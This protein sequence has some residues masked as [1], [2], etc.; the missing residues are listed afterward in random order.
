[1]NTDNDLNHEFLELQAGE[2]PE[3][4]FMGAMRL[5]A[6]VRLF[7]LTGLV[8]LTAAAGLFVFAES[9]LS[10]ALNVAAEADRVMVLAGRLELGIANARG[11]E[12]A[13]LLGKNPATAENF[14]S[15]MAAMTGTL[16]RLA[17]IP[18]AVTMRKHLD[19]IRDGLAQYDEQFTKLLAS[20]KAL[21]LTDGTGL[22]RDL[23]NITED[24]QA[25]FS[26]AGFANLAGQVSRI[27]QEGK[28]TFL[29]GY[30]KGVEEIRKRYQTLIVFLKETKIPGKRKQA[31]RDLLKQHET[32]LLAMINTRFR[33]ADEI[34][35][36][37]DLLSYLAPSTAAIVKFAEAFRNGA[38]KDLGAARVVSRAAI[39]GGGAGLL[40]LLMLVGLMVIRSMT[41]PM[42]ELAAVAKRLANGERVASLPACGNS[43]A[44]GTIAR[45]LDHWQQALADL[46]HVRHEL[47]Q[48]RQ[49]MEEALARAEASDMVASDAVRQALL[50]EETEEPAPEEPAAQPAPEAAPDLSA[51]LP[52]GPISSA[53][54][55]LASFSQYVTAATDDVE[56]TEA[57]IKGLDDTTRQM[58]E[59]GSLVMSVRD[60]TNL[61]AFRSGPRDSGPDNLVILSGEDKEPAEGSNFTDMDMAKRF[62]VIRDTTERA[63]RV[64]TSVRQAMNEVTGMA[65]EIATTA[66]EHA[67]EAT[68]KLLSQSEY[69]RNMLDDV[70]SKVKPSGAAGD[71]DAQ[72]AAGNTKDASRKTPPKKA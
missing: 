15:H 5:G 41:T 35:H 43:D 2:A 64:T 42:R 6:R 36:F 32:Y 26:T 18:A 30:K 66:S 56:R 20:E 68:T 33:Q 67:I 11:V 59:M 45:A 16:N 70:I 27:N 53:S 1:M 38:A 54:R 34:R 8:V 24:L 39:G 29:S 55:Q 47:D 37:D 72:T 7:V 13:F 21:G 44:T 52:G 69:L 4:T 14:Q 57:L 3:R 12:K 48:T 23:Q 19:T 25:K 71:A 50:S 31:L 22:S 58:E 63:E 51:G 9:R 28:E 61:L 65:R 49:R 62:D 10:T 60:Q 46:D 40:V 17:R